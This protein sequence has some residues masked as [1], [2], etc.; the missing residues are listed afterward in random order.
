MTQ[1]PV[2][3]PMGSASENLLPGVPSTTIP[4]PSPPDRLPG[5]LISLGLL[6]LLII[7]V[8]IYVILPQFGFNAFAEM[9]GL[10]LMLAA[11]GLFIGG[12]TYWAYLKFVLSRPHLPLF[13][14]VLAWPIVA[15]LNGLLMDLGLN[16]HLRPLLILSL[17]IPAV[18]MLWRERQLV[19]Q[20]LPS[21]RVYGLFMLWLTLYAFIY[22]A[23]AVDPRLSGGDE[24]MSEGSVSMVQ[25]SSYGYCFLAMALPAIC[26]LKNR[27]Y[28]RM[29]DGLN[30]ALLIISSLESLLTIAGYPLGLFTILL[31]GFTRAIG[32]FTHP[33]PYAHH[34]GILMVYFLGLYCYYQGARKGRMAQWL[35]YGGIII[36]F[37]A[38]LLGLSKTAISVFAISA[39]IVF[40]MN[41]AVPEVRRSFGK[42]LLSL[43]ILIPVGV[44]AFEA[45]S[46]Q[47]FLTLL[48]S[49]MDQTQSMNWRMIVW[50]DLIADINLTTVWLGHG[51]TA[52]NE[53]VYRLTFNDSKNAQPL[54][55][56]H[57]AYIALL[58]DLGLPGYLLL[59]SAVAMLW[60]ALKGWLKAE[61]PASRNTNATRSINATII[62]LV[63]YFLCVCGFDEMSYMFDA[64]MLFWSLASL[65]ACVA[66]RERQHGHQRIK[67][68]GKFTV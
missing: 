43:I 10:K 53:T 11:G 39:A 40:L 5:V 66:I 3:Q 24:A 2:I 30:K 6:F 63:I 41:L 49:R 13:F 34:M 26:I 52:A 31:D 19:W 50:Q 18:C 51:F 4:N 27:D 33:N 55:M 67:A 65:L 23:N 15:W 21:F 1:S 47:S 25:W 48:E 44:I 42:I 17:A 36:N 64:P 20:A 9:L 35:L 8:L 37:C 60:K 54:M 57:N 58:Y 59:L 46:G 14:I 32:I 12:I 61:N 56:V 68:A 38:F 29:F 7:P 22:N 62:A 45:L 28:R 16:L